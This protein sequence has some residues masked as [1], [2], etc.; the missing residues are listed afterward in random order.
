MC[1]RRVC[2]R[3]CVWYVHMRA[4]MSQTKVLMKM[5]VCYVGPCGVCEG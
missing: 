5:S 3:V 4:D 2:V 1:V